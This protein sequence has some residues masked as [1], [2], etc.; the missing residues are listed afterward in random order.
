[1]SY[2]PRSSATRRA[3]SPPPS[4]RAALTLEDGARVVAL[5]VQAIAAGLAGRGGMLSVSLPVDV[6]RGRLGAW[7]GRLSVAAVNGPSS[8]V[9]SG[10]TEALEELLARCEGE[11]VRAKLIPVDYASHSVHVEELRDELRE[12]LGPIVPRSSSVA[13]HSTV[14][15]E[16]I[17]TVQLDA[18]YWFRNLRETVQLEQVTRSLISGGQ[19]FFVEVS[20]HS[21]L[22]AAIEG[23]AEQ[24]EEGATA[25]GTLRREEHGPR[26][27]L[28]SL[29]QA[30]VQGVPVDW[31][32][33]F[34]GHTG[35]PVPLPTYPFQRQ[36]YWL[37][38]AV[39]TGGDGTQ[40]DR[41]EA[42]FWA[43]VQ[44]QDVQ[45]LTSALGADPDTPLSAVVPLLST[46]RAAQN[47]Q[48]ALDKWHYRV[49]WQ[50]VTVPERTTLAGRWLVAVPQEGAADS[51]AGAVVDGLAACGADLVPVPCGDPDRA[52]L[53]EQLRSAVGESG[54]AG[55]LSLLA[56]D[57]AADSGAAV[58]AAV[59]A[60]LALVQALGDAGI[61]APLWLATRGAVSTGDADRLA[62]PDQ[63]MVWG[64]GGAVAL[65]HPERWGG[66][67]D[68]P[69]AFDG[70]SAADLAGVL[71]GGEDEDQVAMRATGVQARRLR[72]TA[73]APAAGGWRPRG[74]VLVTGGTG[75]VGGQLARWLAREGADHV[76]LAGRRGPEAPGAAE[77][78]AELT[79]LGTRV[80]VT[81]CDV[82]DRTALEALLAGL[83]TDAEAPLTAVVHAA[84]V[85]D[86][87]TID[88]LTPQRAATV[89][90]PKATGARHL[91][92]L[93]RGLELEAFV[94]FSSI[95]GTVGAAGQGNYAAANAYLDALARQRRSD[96]LPA[97]SVAWSAW[98]D[99][100][101]VD[102]ELA[103]QLG[104]RGVTALPAD[105]AIAAL[106]AAVGGEASLVVADI[107]W[108]RFAPALSAT[109][110]LPLLRDIAEAAGPDDANGS[111]EQ[112]GASALTRRLAGLGTEDRRTALLD[113]VAEQ[114]AA[115]LG[116]AEGGSVDGRRPFKELGFDSLT[117]VDLRN[118]LNAVT[119][120][121]LPVTLVFDYPTADDL[122]GLLL[123][124]LLPSGGEA[125][126]LLAEL[127]RLQAT[128]SGMNPGDP[129]YEA[130]AE[131]LQKFS[132]NWPD[133]GQTAPPV[134]AA[135]VEEATDEE[136]YELL[137][138]MLALLDRDLRA[139]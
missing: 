44:E 56:L 119:G 61:E 39:A 88:T 18:D 43:A 97:T 14:T 58:P 132:W 5:R 29:S 11:G 103:V 95:A 6:V 49:G 116:Y 77:L 121:R 9:V 45:A 32:A 53:A 79:G 8:A 17:D 15:G 37:E 94:L 96:G 21:V 112:D 50:P 12:V 7:D 127:D 51:L 82:T 55:V 125:A 129:G 41:A 40:A 59:A 66:S 75:G 10:D 63:A 16:V 106:G 115:A 78:A 83:A 111:G 36:R 86:D 92:E 23:T 107:D 131:R 128:L 105:R 136:M 25:I 87:A 91:H 110:R 13:F 133:L 2:R 19:R 26:Q 117:A 71:A 1:M 3:R 108:E 123:A 80:T 126:E 90:L 102:D 57:Q 109:R 135:E 137:D 124:E 138:G 72:R 31:N 70:R 4:W 64:L 30:Y 104:R 120:L 139:S 134:G 122:A 46:W 101:M 52:A 27:F 42:E 113:L 33:V 69:E 68:L 48:A 98:A 114:A 38:P 85:L 73:A 81:A 65:E 24:T 99:S 130:V 22:V 35:P 84:G 93:T 54:A 62:D 28:L 67:V 118:R 74:T 60:S 100:G 89:L 34:G 20:P 76:V 47:E